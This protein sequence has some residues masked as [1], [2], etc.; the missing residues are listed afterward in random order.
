[1]LPEEPAGTGTVL[2]TATAGENKGNKAVYETATNLRIPRPVQA[3]HG[4]NTELSSREAEAA[5]HSQVSLHYSA[6]VS[7]HKGDNEAH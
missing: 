2:H 7:E 5:S 4:V 3:G 1:M 6:L